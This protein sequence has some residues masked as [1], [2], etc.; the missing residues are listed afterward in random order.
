ML[1]PT[2]SSG[3]WHWSMRPIIVQLWVCA[4]ITIYI[5]LPF[6]VSAINT[7]ILLCVGLIITVYITQ[8][9]WTSNT[10][11]RGSL[12]F[13]LLPHTSNGCIVSLGSDRCNIQLLMGE[14]CK[15]YKMHK[16]Q[17][18]IVD[19][20]LYNFL[21]FVRGSLKLILAAHTSAPTKVALSQVSVIDVIFTC[22]VLRATLLLPTVPASPS[23]CWCLAAQLVHPNGAGCGGCVCV[24]MEIL[25]AQGDLTFDP[26][27]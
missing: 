20:Q 15:C 24:N 2:L 1:L 22:A 4:I 10:C 26:V 23:H 8:G 18:H 12:K 16:H 11:V 6:G 13:V 27:F 19:V 9:D 3:G 21:G 5:L 17:H 25:R 14:M 7:I